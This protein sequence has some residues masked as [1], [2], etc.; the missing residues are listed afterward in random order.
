MEKG[1]Q[2]QQQGIISGVHP[3]E[4]SPLVVC[5]ADYLLIPCWSRHGFAYPTAILHFFLAEFLVINNSTNSSQFKLE[6]S[7]FKDTGSSQN[8]QEGWKIRLEDYITWNNTQIIP[9]DCSSGDPWPLPPITWM[10]CA[11][12]YHSAV[13][14]NC[15][16]YLKCSSSFTG[17][18]NLPGI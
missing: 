9:P 18:R 8:P 6:R 3:T 1:S 15:I 14:E 11:R 7:F 10:Q 4:Y 5:S 12:C 13:S 17:K 16:V 2:V